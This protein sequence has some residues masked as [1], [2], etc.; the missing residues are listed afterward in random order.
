M[1]HIT[2]CRMRLRGCILELAVEADEP[3]VT[4]CVCA[5]CADAATPE[6]GFFKKETTVNLGSCCW[7]GTSQFFEATHH[8]DDIQVSVTFASGGEDSVGLQDVP[9][10]WTKCETGQESVDRQ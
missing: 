6:E 1:P 3:F 5:F 4:V 10:E 7:E 9:T 8:I 2:Q